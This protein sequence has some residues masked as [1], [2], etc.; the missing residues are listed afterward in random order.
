[1]RLDKNS[2]RYGVAI[3]VK[4]ST[5]Y[6]AKPYYYKHKGFYNKKCYI[7]TDEKQRGDV[8]AIVLKFETGEKVGII[9]CHLEGGT[10]QKKDLEFDKF[11]ENNNKL[12]NKHSTF[13]M[14]QIQ[15]ILGFKKQIETKEQD[16]SSWIVAG[17]FNWNF[18]GNMHKYN[19]QMRGPLCLPRKEWTDADPRA[20]A[21]RFPLSTCK[22]SDQY[23]KNKPVR[24]DYIFFKGKIKQKKLNQYKLTP[25]DMLSNLNIFCNKIHRKKQ[26]RYN[27][28][29][30]VSPIIENNNHAIIM[31]KFEI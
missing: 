6:T 1:M 10:P 26:S 24:Q 4:K 9:G 5:R 29:Y 17:D 11:Y 18:D 21:G 14:Y 12:S 22:I 19:Q 27:N 20:Q 2:F 25:K 7:G 30:T 16:I 3:A 28:S 13:C 8:L 23:I 15:K 31:S